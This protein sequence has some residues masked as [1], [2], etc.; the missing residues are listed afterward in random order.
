MGTEAGGAK[1]VVGLVV[2]EK[3]EVRSVEWTRFYGSNVVSCEIA[4]GIQRMTPIGAHVPIS[5][6]DQLPD[7]EGEL[8]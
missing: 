2:R 5:N 4:S 8:N 1:G 3:T 6:I 7:L